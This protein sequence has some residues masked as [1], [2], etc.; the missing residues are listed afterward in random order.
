MQLH[1]S[2]NN[3]RQYP[4]KSAYS[5]N[6][7]FVIHVRTKKQKNKA[8]ISF[9]SLSLSF[10]QITRLYFFKHQYL[11]F[12]YQRYM[13][14]TLDAAIEKLK[15]Y[16]LKGVSEFPAEVKIRTTYL[17][18]FNMAGILLMSTLLIVRIF[19]YQGAFI[20]TGDLLLLS[21]L[22]L[23]LLFIRQNKPVTASA[24][25]Y[26]LPVSIIFYRVFHNYFY[27]VPV[28][29]DDLFFTISLAEFGIIHMGTFSIRRNQILIYSLITASVLLIQTVFLAMRSPEQAVLPQNISILIISG[30]LLIASVLVLY[31]SRGVTFSMKLNSEHSHKQTESKYMSLFSNMMDMFSLQKIVL[32]EN[33][34]P[35]DSII[36]EANDAFIRFTGLKRESII[37]KKSSGIIPG[38]NS[39]S[40]WLKAFGQVSLTGKE[41]RFEEYS[42]YYQRWLDVYA[43]SPEKEHFIT[44]LRDVT[45]NRATDEALRLSERKN[46]A[47]IEALPDPIF[48]IDE[49]G[50]LPEVLSDGKNSSADSSGA[51]KLNIHDLSYP[52]ET[53]NRILASVRMALSAGTQQTIEYDIP[54]DGDRV[55]FEARLVALNPTHVLM[56]N[57]NITDRKLSEIK[58]VRAKEKAVESDRL[59]SAFLANMSHEVL[60]PMNAIMGF[61]QILNEESLSDSD[62][63]EFAALIRN[64]GQMLISLINDIVDLS[65]IEAGETK[66]NITRFEIDPLFGQLNNYYTNELVKAGKE[67]IRLSFYISSA[68]NPVEI[69]C[70][71]N[72]LQQILGNLLDNAIKFTKRGS[73]EAGC[74]VK[75]NNRIEFYVKDT[76]IGI[77]LEKQGV[78]FER[79]R[80]VEEDYNRTYGGTGIGLALVKKLV[81]LMGGNI[82]LISEHGQGSEFRISLNLVTTQKP[83]KYILPVVETHEVQRYDWAG[84]TILV[85]EDIQTNYIF[86][87]RVIS[88]LNAR[89]LQAQ[90]GAQALDLVKSGEKIDLI[91]MDLQMPEMNGIEAFNLIRHYNPSIRIILQT[92]YATK[93]E[94]ETYRDMGFDGFL[95]KPIQ[96]EPLVAMIN[97][98]LTNSN[99]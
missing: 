49:N 88:R 24:M 6:T 19:A 74:E 65:R 3:G 56:V 33:G 52:V 57:R 27:E 92:A 34:K 70:D 63:R 79:F 29:Y 45:L 16:F 91:L 28:S 82:T 89:V 98:V 9:Y 25:I 76:G 73:I 77:P 12:R 14:R 2:L 62:R 94:K 48:I 32:D 43:F 37:G 90:N 8:G 61:S 40:G 22:L 5:E 54:A 51:N 99:Q 26:M 96:I 78:I 36:I 7:A 64:S 84:K 93:D 81:E 4:V 58:L 31:Y 83:P 55:Y 71:R 60:T 20:L 1:T 46:K 44:I 53:V 50:N 59:K 72:R 21:G 11:I 10:N 30:L 17:L 85:T 67:D 66:F 86:L 68:G 47:I 41:T 38:L 13:S 95:T 18:L 75:E 97:K 15:S 39:G 69:E 23:S 80:Q 87:E 42:D 35:T